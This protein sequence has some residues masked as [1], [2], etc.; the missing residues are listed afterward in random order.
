MEHL[1]VDR[2]TSPATRN[3]EGIENDFRSRP[4][5]QPTA[6]AVG[7]APTKTGTLFGDLSLLALSIPCVILAGGILLTALQ[8]VFLLVLAMLLLALA[9]LFALLFIFLFLQ[10]RAHHIESGT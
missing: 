8:P 6:P 2:E 10:D 1:I 7:P 4:G 9:P 5:P 3:S